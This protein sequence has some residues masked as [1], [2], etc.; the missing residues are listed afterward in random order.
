MICSNVNQNEV[1]FSSST[2]AK[3]PKKTAP[4]SH[5]EYDCSNKSDS[6]KEETSIFWQF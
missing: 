2:P 4:L 1:D 6:F 3:N 5:D